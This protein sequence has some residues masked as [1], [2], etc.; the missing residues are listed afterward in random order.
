MELGELEEFVD[1]AL[2]YGEKLGVP[3]I[4][5]RLEDDSVGEIHLEKGEVKE[6][7][8]LRDIGFAVRVIYNGVSGFAFT[9]RLKK[10]SVERVVEKA[11]Q[12][13]KVGD[14]ITALRLP[15]ADYEPVV[16]NPS[17]PPI[18]QHP[19][20]VSFEDKKDMVMRAHESAEDHGKSVASIIVR[21]GEAYGT[22]IVANSEGARVKWDPWTVEI[23]CMVISKE[24][25]VLADAWDRH[26]GSIGLEI[27]EGR[28]SPERLGENAAKWAGEKLVSKRAPAGKQRAIVDNK[29]TGVL[30][31]ESFGHQT[32]ADLMISGAVVLKDRMGEKLG[33]ENVTIVDE[34]VYEGDNADI[35]QGW[36]C[37]YDDE[38]VR[39]EKVVMLDQGVLSSSLNS[40]GTAKC[41]GSKPTGNA[42][43]LDFRF[44]PIVRMRNTYFTPG[45]LSFEEALELLKDGI[46]AIDTFG[47]QAGFDGTFMFKAIRG[48]LVRKG[49]IVEPLRD[50]AIAGNILDF[51]KNVEGATRD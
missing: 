45:D 51:L 39:A 31:H 10:D 47:G 8:A 6:S 23:V 50:V 11:F 13:A 33:S 21:Y 29:L 34:G 26:G 37:P 35:Y 38:G 42:R 30:A 49:E 7:K 17:I 46:Y 40:R 12:A 1:L 18:K 2:G 44:E 36:W 20:D 27:F 28:F 3:F 41:M 32:E 5:V 43:A 24:G 14:K 25:E 15:F 9:T 22:K 19:K 48:Y 4:E 16:D